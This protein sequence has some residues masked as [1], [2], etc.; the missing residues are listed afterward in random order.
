MIHALGDWLYHRALRLSA[1]AV[2]ILAARTGQSVDRI[3]AVND[4][5]AG[6][7][8]HEAVLLAQKH[9]AGIDGT[10]TGS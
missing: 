3:V 10:L 8:A 1:S 7:A 5:V 4:A 2:K 9:A 6:I